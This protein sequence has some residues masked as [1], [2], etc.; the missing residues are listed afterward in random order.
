MYELKQYKSCFDK[1]CLGFYQ[2]NQ[3]K[4]Q[5]VQVPSQNNV[6]NLNNVRR[7]ASRH[8]RN[9]RIV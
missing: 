7:D 3:A 8:F 5:W 1:E 4:M 9:I 2:R 6:D